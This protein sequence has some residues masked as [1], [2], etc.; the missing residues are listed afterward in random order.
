MQELKTCLPVIR[1]KSKSILVMSF[2]KEETQNES[3]RENN[4]AISSVSHFFLH[5]FYH[6]LLI[7]LAYVSGY[8]SSFHIKS[9]SRHDPLRI[10]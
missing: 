5:F 8:G 1:N 7:Q 3:H 4:K 9:T 2:Q 6:N 10:E